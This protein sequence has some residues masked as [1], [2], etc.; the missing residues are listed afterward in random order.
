MHCFSLP[1]FSRYYDLSGENL[2]A[3]FDEAKVVSPYKN[4]SRP[5]SSASG[6]QGGAIP[7]TIECDIC[8]MPS[9]KSVRRGE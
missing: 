3:L 8:Y 5:D 4:K 6:S 7:K 2:E 9:H 1:S